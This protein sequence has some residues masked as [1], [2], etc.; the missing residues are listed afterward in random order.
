MKVGTVAVAE[1]FIIEEAQMILLADNVLFLLVIGGRSS[2][3]TLIA[4]SPEQMLGR[5]STVALQPDLPSSTD[6]LLN[7]ISTYLQSGR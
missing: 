4:I 5:L 7:V 2:E 6:V 1:A 3:K